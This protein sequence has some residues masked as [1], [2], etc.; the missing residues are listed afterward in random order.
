M[1]TAG[2]STEPAVYRGEHGVL[3]ATS[4]LGLPGI[5]A[6]SVQTLITS[7]PAWEPGAGGFGGEGSLE[8]YLGK[9]RAHAEGWRRALALDGLAWVVTET[10]VRKGRWVDVPGRTLQALEEI[11]FVARQV[12]VWH[13]PGRPARTQSGIT[14]SHKRILGLTPTTEHMPRLAWPSPDEVWAIPRPQAGE[15][16]YSPLPLA[17]VEQLLRLCPDHRGLVLDPF[18]GSGTVPGACERSGRPWVAF[19]VDHAQVRL[20]AGRLSLKREASRNPGHEG[21]PTPAAQGT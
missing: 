13:Y 16:R 15:A 6:G 9:L 10:T 8:A 2:D 11:G 18:A 4:S 1:R 7:P 17:L 19:E 20:A 21:R 5:R 12:V 14:R 3:Y